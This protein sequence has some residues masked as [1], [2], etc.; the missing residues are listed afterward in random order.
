MKL[1]FHSLIQ[2]F[3][4]SQAFA[5]I[6]P[7]H[8]R[9]FAN[10][11]GSLQKITN[12]PLTSGISPNVEKY[13]LLMVIGDSDPGGYRLPSE[14]IPGVR[15][16]IISNPSSGTGDL[17][18]RAEEGCEGI[19]P[20]RSIVVPKNKDHY[21]V[22]GSD[23]FLSSIQKCDES[24]VEL[25][26][27]Q[28]DILSL[29]IKTSNSSTFD[30][31]VRVISNF[32]DRRFQGIG[33]E[34]LVST[35]SLVIRHLYVDGSGRATLKNPQSLLQSKYCEVTSGEIVVGKDSELVLL[36]EPVGIDKLT[37]VRILSNTDTSEARAEEG[38]EGLVRNEDLMILKN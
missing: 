9:G 31:K 3:L 25:D 36:N 19:L 22:W 33:C 17:S 8:P 1:F 26:L 30:I 5:Q 34:G 10:L 18:G 21:Q 12:C 13:A 35:S 24:F 4:F 16:R 37:K 20:T 6:A 29:P 7:A 27:A 23:D 32:G 14:N 2:L 28:L 11:K 38:C 15:V